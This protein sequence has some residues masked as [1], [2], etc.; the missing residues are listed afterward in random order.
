[1]LAVSVVLSYIIY[2]RC[3]NALSGC[4]KKTFDLLFFYLADT[5]D[6]LRNSVRYQHPDML[7]GVDTAIPQN[8]LN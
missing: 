3:V 2:R 7:P 5:T 4:L 8:R 1:M 6:F